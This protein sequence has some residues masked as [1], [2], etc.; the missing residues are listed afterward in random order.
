VAKERRDV[1]AQLP[2]ARSRAEA[3]YI[4]RSMP[5]RWPLYVRIHIEYTETVLS[6]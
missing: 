4:V 5:D 3:L 6:S 2:T 1:S